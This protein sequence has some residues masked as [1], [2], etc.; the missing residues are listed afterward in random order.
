MRATSKNCRFSPL[1][2]TS[3]PH[4]NLFTMNKIKLI[5]LLIA[6]SFSVAAKDSE[7]VAARIAAQNALFEEEYQADLKNHP[8]RATAIGDYRY[9]DQLDDFSP[10]AFVRQNAEDKKYL[11]RLDAISTAGFGDQDK[12]SHEV[13]QRLLAQRLA[14]FRF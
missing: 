13:M 12:L 1:P 10:A 5:A 6:C 4:A 9:N 8:E 11:S 2:R 3:P 7:S 14:N